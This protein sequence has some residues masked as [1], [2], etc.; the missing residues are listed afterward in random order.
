MSRKE[1]LEFLLNRVESRQKELGELSSYLLELE[2]QLALIF[3][4]S[5]DMIVFIH[6]DGRII[7]I[8]QAVWKILGYDKEEIV[9]KYIWDFIHPDDVGK[10]QRIRT[11]LIEDKFLYFDYQNYFTNRWRHK[12]GYYIK[13]AWKFSLYDDRE[14]QTIGIA[15]DIT[16]LALE[17]PFHFNLVHK[18]VELTNDGIVI[19]NMLEPDNPII[20]ANKAF[21]KI[22]G[23]D[24][25]DL[26]GMNCRLLQ[27]DNKRQ[28]AL[29]TI[30]DAIA[31]GESCEVL[32][33]N[34]KKDKTVFFNHVLISPIL[35]NG[36][37][38]NYI[39][40]SRD[41]TPLIENGIYVWD[42]NA[43]RGFGKNL[44]ANG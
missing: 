43:P 13:L 23:Y 42:E 33:R 15:T 20:Y 4:A 36:I 40:I 17:N 1:N 3:A 35:D 18:A 25:T 2:S 22:T 5:P 30:R 7:K 38:T 26:I 44:K 12:K 37:V 14:D 9:G 39:G 27:S 29:D 32:L 19:T 41:L 6:H 24:Q 16:N 11:K 28:K 34:Y 8:S 10:T 21:C 31:N